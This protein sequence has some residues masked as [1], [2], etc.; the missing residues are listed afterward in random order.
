MIYE[1]FF[2]MNILLSERGLQDVQM[3]GIYLISFHLIFVAYCI[4]KVISIFKKSSLRMTAK[5]I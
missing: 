4:Y 1:P 2:N 5:G 3:F